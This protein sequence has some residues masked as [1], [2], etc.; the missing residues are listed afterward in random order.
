[1][2]TTVDMVCQCGQ[3]PPHRIDCPTVAALHRNAMV[4]PDGGILY[5]DNPDDA[6]LMMQIHDARY[7]FADGDVWLITDDGAVAT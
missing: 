7:L 1:M 6:R 2:S 3:P 5:P 4:C